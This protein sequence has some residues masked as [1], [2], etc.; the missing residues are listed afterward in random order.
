[1]GIIPFDQKN[2][3]YICKL[4]RQTET[5]HI[6][7]GANRQA[8]DKL[9]LTIEVCRECHSRIYDNPKDYEHIKTYAQLKAMD[10]YNLSFDDWRKLFRKDYS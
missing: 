10:K 1:M 2:H 6:F 7:Q 4:N 5:H 8:S 9:G 3:C